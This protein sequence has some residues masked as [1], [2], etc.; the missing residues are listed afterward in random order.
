M[1]T[2]VAGSVSAEDVLACLEK[3]LGSSSFRRAKAVSALLRHIVTRT[4]EGRQDELKEYS[5]GVDVLGRVPSFDNRLDPIVRVQMRKLRGRLERYYQTE[6]KDDIVRIELPLGGYVPHF[7]VAVSAPTQ[8]ALVAAPAQE[9]PADD[10]AKRSES[11]LASEVSLI[12]KPVGIEERLFSVI[13]TIYE[14]AQNEE[15]WPVFLTALSRMIRGETTALLAH[16][17]QRRQ[18][19][20]EIAVGVDHSYEKDYNEYY[21]ARN[22]WVTRGTRFLKTGLVYV[23]QMACPDEEFKRTEF[24]NDYLRRLNLF[25][26]VG[27]TIE[28]SSGSSSWITS[29]RPYSAGPFGPTEMKILERLLPHLRRALDLRRRL[30]GLQSES[31]YLGAALDRVPQGCIFLDHDGRVARMNRAA[32]ELLNK[33]DGLC[34]HHGRLTAVFD[35]ESRRLHELI[36]SALRGIRSDGQAGGVMA[37]A[38]KSTEKP[39][40]V[41]VFALRS[42]VTFVGAPRARVVLFVSDPGWHTETNEDLL[43]QLYGLTPAE[44]KITTL[45]GEG[46]SLEKVSELLSIT[47]NTAKSHLAKIFQKTDTR[48]QSELVRLLVSLEPCL[49]SD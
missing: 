22:P 31:D 30:S 13:E 41:R 20:V 12:C 2:P 46:E 18:S 15:Q 45:L 24:Y 1:N 49:T 11:T 44:A 14:A 35:I 29:L 37:I 43:Q 33:G 32:E 6:G 47:R 34:T 28:Q 7:Q 9:Q 48:R 27:G 23:G 42:P 3:V 16:D 8:L 17:H 40:I 26:S 25:H 5:L 39:Y 21:S 4:L 36:Q 10:A 19:A 38:R